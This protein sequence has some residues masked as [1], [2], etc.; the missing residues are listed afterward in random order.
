MQRYSPVYVYVRD[1]DVCH[2]IFVPALRVKP[3]NSPLW[4]TFRER[5]TDWVLRTGLYARNYCA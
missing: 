1:A 2:K 4:A 3:T 5:G